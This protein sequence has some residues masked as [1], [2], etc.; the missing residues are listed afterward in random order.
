MIVHIP[1]VYYRGGGDVSKAL[2]RGC[3]SRRPEV[4]ERIVCVTRL[5]EQHACSLLA[6]HFSV[7]SSDIRDLVIIGDLQPQHEQL[8]V[9]TD[10]V[11]YIVSP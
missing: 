11:Y 10:Q 6:S 5:M 2:L 8:V 1:R 9:N 7:R 4:R 3:S